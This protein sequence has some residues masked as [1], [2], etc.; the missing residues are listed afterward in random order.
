MRML[1]TL[2][3]REGE[4]RAEACQLGKYFLAAHHGVLPGQLCGSCP[5]KS[6]ALSRL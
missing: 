2:G 6:K 3:L 1:G 5:D 4:K